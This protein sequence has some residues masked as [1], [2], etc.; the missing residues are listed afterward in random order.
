MRLIN[1]H[2]LLAID[3]FKNYGCEVYKLPQEVELAIVEEA[4][5]YY[6]EKAAK[7]DPIYREILESM[8]NYLE[9]YSKK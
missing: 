2:K 9:A 7:E 1:G 3:K 8:T 6:S 5:K 4:Q